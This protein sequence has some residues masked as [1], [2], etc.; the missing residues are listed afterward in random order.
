MVLA[1][2][3]KSLCL[4]R[5]ATYLYTRSAFQKFTSHS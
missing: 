4:K 2:G 3:K 5:E 1:G